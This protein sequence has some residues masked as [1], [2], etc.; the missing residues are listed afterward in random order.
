MAQVE[1]WGRPSH[2]SQQ[3]MHISQQCPAEHCKSPYVFRKK[4]RKSGSLELPQLTFLESGNFLEFTT[5]F[6]V[7][8]YITTQCSCQN[9]V[10]VRVIYRLPK[11]YS[12]QLLTA[13]KGRKIVISIDGKIPGSKA[14]GLLWTSYSPTQGCL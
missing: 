11:T 12:K 8:Q 4:R 13:C 7:Y 14:P 6:D 1:L 10:S 3:P 2:C 5:S 9:H